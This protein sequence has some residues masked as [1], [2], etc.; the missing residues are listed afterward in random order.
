M[1]LMVMAGEVLAQP[2]R[3]LAIRKA[4]FR[5]LQPTLAG[6]ANQMTPKRSLKTP[7]RTKLILLALGMTKPA[8]KKM[9]PKK[10]LPRKQLGTCG[11]AL[12][13]VRLRQQR[14]RLPER[15]KRGRR[16]RRKKRGRGKRQKRSKQEGMQR[17]L[18]KLPRRW[19]SP[20]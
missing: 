12:G 17:R 18:P 2:K 6:R 20:R 19:R 3:S 10:S 11:P 9:L 5:G 7:K 8:P 1:I 16:E 15:G 4:P 14:P 13:R